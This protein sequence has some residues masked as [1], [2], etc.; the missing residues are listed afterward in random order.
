MFSLSSVAR[1]ERQLSSDARAGIWA[2]GKARR[3]QRR[4][5]RLNWR[6]LLAVFALIAGPTLLALPFIPGDFQRGLFVGVGFTA[7]TSV[8]AYFVTQVTGT[9][10]TMMGA[11]AEQWTASELRP[12]RKHGWK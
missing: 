12:L 7:A 2:T 10:S 8:V 1:R 5:V 11:T 4:V 9:G 6:L 3:A